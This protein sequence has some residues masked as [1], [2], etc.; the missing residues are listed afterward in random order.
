MKI[1]ID[2]KSYKLVLN[3]TG[4]NYLAHICDLAKILTDCATG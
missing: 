2:F 3:K 1:L 4:S